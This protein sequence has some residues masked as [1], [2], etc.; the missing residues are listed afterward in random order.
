MSD[1]TPQH[2]RALVLGC[3][4]VCGAAWMVATLAELERALGWDA[5]RADVLIG[6]S[7]GAL[8]AALLGAGVSVERMV[9]SQLGELADDCWNHEVDWG[10]SRPPR[11]AFGF[12]A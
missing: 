9:K 10:A 3:G 4:G 2:Q 8:I 6:T 11:P 1:R 5:R 7:A 12:T